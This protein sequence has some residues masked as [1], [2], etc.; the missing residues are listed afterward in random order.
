MIEIESVYD[1][2]PKYDRFSE[3][4]LTRLFSEFQLG[5]K[6]LQKLDK[7]LKRKNIAFEQRFIDEIIEF[8]NRQEKKY[9]RML[10]DLFTNTDPDDKEELLQEMSWY[11]YNKYGVMNKMLEWEMDLLDKNNL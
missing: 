3:I 6:D 8:L 2:V 5:I 9:F 7:R 10:K 1:G 11:I 4:E